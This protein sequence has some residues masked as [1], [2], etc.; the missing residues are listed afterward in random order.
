[1]KISE[2]TVEKIA[3]YLRIDEPN[4]DELSAYLSSAKSCIV[5]Y[6][7]L[8]EEELDTKEDATQACLVLISDM[9]ENHLYHQGGVGVSVK[10]NSIVDTI[11]NC[12]RVNLL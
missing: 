3:Q 12:H 11:L 8:T 1:M 7:G 5:S 10:T 2:I 4:N 6:T 9:Y